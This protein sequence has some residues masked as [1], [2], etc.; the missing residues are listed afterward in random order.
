LGRQFIIEVSANKAVTIDTCYIVDTYSNATAFQL[1]PDSLT[2]DST[3]YDASVVLSGLELG[4]AWLHVIGRD[5]HGSTSSDSVRVSVIT[6]DAFLPEDRVYTWP[7]P[8]DDEVHFRFFVNR[9]ADITIEIFNI[10]GRK[11]ATLEE[12]ASGG[13]PRSEVLWQTDNVGSDLYIYR[14]TARSVVARE[15]ETFMGKFAIVK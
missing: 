1:N 10:A 12:F 5:A 7:N 11:I 14:L 3:N 9:N 6:E 2:P 4:T 15:K 8:A 13:D